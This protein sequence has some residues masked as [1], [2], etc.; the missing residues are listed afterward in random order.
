MDCLL[1]CY[2]RAMMNRTAVL[3]ATA[4][5]EQLAARTAELAR[6]GTARRAAMLRMRYAHADRLANR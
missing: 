5:L 1:S 4:H 2:A 3:A 6:A